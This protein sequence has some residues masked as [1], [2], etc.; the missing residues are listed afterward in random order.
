M[1]S[2]SCFLVACGMMVVSMSGA[3]TQEAA[4]APSGAASTYLEVYDAVK[5]LDGARGRTAAVQNLVLE[6]EAAR[7]T[8]EQGTMQLLTPVNGRTVGAV[9]SGRGRMSFVPHHRLER[10]QLYRFFETEELDEEITGLLLLFADSTLEELESKLTFEAITP[11]RIRDIV[12]EALDYLG[13][14]DERYLDSDLLRALLN[15]ERSDFF[16]A[17][18]VRRRGDPLMVKISPWAAEEVQLHRRADIRGH[19]LFEVVSQG[20]TRAEYAGGTATDREPGIGAVV[21]HYAIESTL[22]RNAAGNVRYSARVD[23]DVLGGPLVGPWIVFYLYPELE[24]DSALWVDGESAEAFKGKESPTLWVRAN[25]A[26]SE[27]TPSTLRLFYH[28]DLFERIGEWFFINSSSAWYPRSLV[29]LTRATFDLTYHSPTSYVL[30]SVGERTDSVVDGRTVT[31]RWVVSQPIRN[32]SFNL[33]LFEVNTVTLEG[34]PPVMVLYSERGHRELRRVLG[35]QRGIRGEVGAD[36]STSLKFFQHVFGESPI[37]QFYATE[38]PDLHGEA[39]PGLIHLSFA[40]FMGTDDEGEGQ[41]FRAHEVAH[42]WWGI[43]VDYASYHDQWLSEGF[44][45]FAGLWYLQTERRDNEK[46]FTLLRRWKDALLDN[47]RS[48]FTRGKQAGPVWM[49]YRTSTS[50]SEGASGLMVYQKGAWVLHMLRNLMLDLQTM[51]EDAFTAMVQDF[52]GSYRGKQATT[53]DFQRVV[54]R[55]VG[56]PMDWFFDQWVYGTAIPT[57]RVAYRVEPAPEGKYRMTVRVRQEN[58][59]DDFQMY[60]PVSVDLGQNRWARLRVKVQGPVSEIALPLMPL[61]PQGIR[62]NELESVLAEVKME[63]W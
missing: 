43:G 9:F 30:A 25:G 26:L 29:P 15:G 11:S 6:R 38:I 49:G 55:H 20:H 52:Y 50:T 16:Y 1:R 7:F 53:T 39:F 27:D 61:E 59:P 31:T 13:E 33:G 19:R 10:E 47:R 35:E 2:S 41:V 44:S 12:N 62:F 60:V 28:G 3:V 54:E 17:H 4:S 46:Y 21:R 56:M 37:E 36:V 42:Q 5:G 48:M 32:A 57:Y 24:L 22:D 18:V 40:T 63:R 45:E 34:A 58:V 8:L 51:K 14:E 23:I